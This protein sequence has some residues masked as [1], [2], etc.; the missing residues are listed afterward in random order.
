MK[1]KTFYIILFFFIAVCGLLLYFFYFRPNNLDD[2]LNP[3]L[4]R[5]NP[6]HTPLP[7]LNNEHIDVPDANYTP[8][9]TPETTPA[10]T[11]VKTPSASTPPKSASQNV[12]QNVGYRG[13]VTNVS[14]TSL[15]FQPVTPA[16]EKT[17]F[18]PIQED[19]KIT[20]VILKNS[21]E[22]RTNI[23]LQDLKPSDEIMITG[24]AQGYNESIEQ[25]LTIERFRVE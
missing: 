17:I 4:L 6:H 14:S 12:L 5:H 2:F 11:P 10:I 13:I 21:G 8:L 1:A 25:T 9:P 20:Q 22:E 3:N 15:K 24:F 23:T 7:I 16:G 18:A 19:T